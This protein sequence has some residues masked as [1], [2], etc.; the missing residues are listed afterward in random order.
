MMKA[1]EDIYYHVVTVGGLILFKLAVLVVGYLIARLG[2][3]LLIK[4][5]SGQF[6]FQAE[7]KGTKA[8]LVS[9]SPGLFFTLMATAL[10]VIAVVKDKPFETTVTTTSLASGA[11][12]QSKRDLPKAK[13]VLSEPPEKETR[14]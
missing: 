5:V 6:K 9:A 2:H 1:S 14:P 3:D 12:H 8:D 7:I 10:I 4:G 11:E 13:P